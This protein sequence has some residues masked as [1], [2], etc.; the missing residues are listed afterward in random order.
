MRSETRNVGDYQ[1]KVITQPGVIVVEVTEIMDVS[2]TIPIR[3][4][5]QPSID[6]VSQQ[7]VPNPVSPKNM[8]PSM[9]AYT[10]PSPLMPP[11]PLPVPASTAAP[12]DISSAPSI[13][14]G[15]SWLAE[16]TPKSHRQTTHADSTLA[17]AEKKSSRSA[18]NSRDPKA[19]RL[20]DG[21]VVLISIVVVFVSAILLYFYVRRRKQA[22]NRRV[23]TSRRSILSSSNSGPPSGGAENE[24]KYFGTGARPGMRMLPPDSGTS[25]N[26]QD[27]PG[28]DKH[29]QKTVHA[30]L[31]S[32]GKNAKPEVPGVTEQ[33]ANASRALGINYFGYRSY[34]VL[35]TSN[36]EMAENTGLATARSDIFDCASSGKR[37]DDA[38]PNQVFEDTEAFSIM[39]ASRVAAK[40]GA[41]S[42]DHTA[43]QNPPSALTRTKTSLEARK[44]HVHEYI[45]AKAKP[46]NPGYHAAAVPPVEIDDGS[47]LL[48]TTSA[49]P[50]I[51]ST[52]GRSN[53][54]MGIK[55]KPRKLIRDAAKHSNSSTQ[56]KRKQRPTE[57]NVMAAVANSPIDEQCQEISPEG[58]QSIQEESKPQ[59]L[60][61]NT[62]KQLPLE[63]PPH[64]DNAGT[65][66][67]EAPNFISLVDSI[68]SLSESYQFAV[69]HK[70][71][72]GPL[73]VV[74]PHAPTLPDELRLG[75]GEKM[76]VIGEFADG[77]VLAINTSRSNECGMIPRR[78]LF[79]P[80][81]PFATHKSVLEPDF[82][83]PAFST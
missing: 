30:A 75:R 6:Q 23:V 5:A 61:N 29:A 51:D 48:D 76:F 56:D 58:S 32:P 60:V 25:I 24:C 64:T 82:Q 55:I 42:F 74:E 11:M 33:D 52:K 17:G 57:P 9:S 27:I 2:P 78:C 15:G 77:W 50:G 26:Y 80:S 14:S 47:S 16:P 43:L 69:R 63:S 41:I 3:I 71:P 36:S 45:G 38:H 40:R 20:P 81:A 21:F 34:G 54:L 39:L 10:P 7:F 73:H 68:E 62:F 12:F 46:V 28:G 18:Y 70:P 8:P 65:Q 67:R 4:P 37:L 59:Q 1:T 66:H 72:L 22:K 19:Y 53:N 83:P 13:A 49:N 31:S 44:T 79:F 35:G